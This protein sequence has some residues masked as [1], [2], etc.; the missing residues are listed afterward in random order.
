MGEGLGFHAEAAIRDGTGVRGAGIRG[1]EAVARSTEGAMAGAG[2]GATG[3]GVGTGAGDLTT[4]AGA[5]LAG[6]AGMAADASAEFKRASPIHSTAT[7][8]ATKRYFMAREG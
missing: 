6:E 8:A 4:G 5:T 2:G 3:R 7:K 1:A